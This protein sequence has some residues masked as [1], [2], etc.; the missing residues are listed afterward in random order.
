[1]DLIYSE[2]ID[3]LIIDRG[4]LNNYRFDMSFGADDNDFVLHCPLSGTHLQVNNVVY[5]NDT[6]YGGVIDSI[7]VD[8]ANQEL[9][10]RGR[11]WQGILESKVIYPRRGEDYYT[12][13]GEANAVLADLLERMNI[14]PGA[15]N[16]LI[17]EP[18]GAIISASTEDSGIYITAAAKSTSGN[19]VNGYT[20][21]RDLLYQYSAKPQI[22][23]GVISAVPLINYSNSDDF[24]EGTDQFTAKRNYNSLNHIHCM[25]A[26]D[27][28]NRYEIDLFLD[29][30]GGVLP[31][32]K[33][34][35]YYGLEGAT[36][37]NQ[38]LSDDDYYTDLANFPLVDEWDVK[39]HETLINNMVTGVNEI[40]MI[41]DYPNASTTYHYS[42]QTE[43]PADWTEDLTPSAEKLS[44]KKFGFQQ[45]FY[46][47]ETDGT[48]NYKSVPKPDTAERY[49][50]LLS[51]PEKWA[52]EFNN[53]YVA[54]GKGFKKVTS[55]NEYD[56]VATRPND[57]FMGGYENY[58]EIGTG[59]NY[60]KVTQKSRYERQQEQ[61]PGWFANYTD[62]YTLEGGT[63]KKVKAVKDA[64]TYE[65]L[66][67]KPKDWKNNFK[68]Y[69]KSD[70]ISF[71]A[72]TGITKYKFVKQTYQP[73]DW[74]NNYKN[75]YK[76]ANDK[77]VQLTN[78]TVPKWTTGKYYTKMSY[79]VAPD[80]KTMLYYVKIP[81][82]SHAPFF[83][84]G[85]YYAFVKSIPDFVANH[86]YEK[87]NY[88]R[89]AANTYYKAV[90]YQPAP[91]WYEN[92]FFTRY[93][94]HYEA[95]ING[96]L[97][98]AQKSNPKDELSI[99]LD[100][101]RIY[102][103]NDI[104]GASDEVTG[105]GATERITQKIVKIERGVISFDYKTGI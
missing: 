76:A 9:I 44:D 4:V 10:Y 1:M 7:E 34:M 90:T 79:T 94:D 61:P 45:Y 46:F 72:V 51:E 105:I 86:F 32:C 12:V 3:G 49:D 18:S 100:E 83:Y 98:K 65:K 30:N 73:S 96:A 99:K 78:K 2:V 20:F 89:Y 84:S 93:E 27:W 13:S 25:G 52:S 47:E 104:V 71:S 39:N 33:Y 29:E 54:D 43:Q 62:Y 103:I 56:P 82:A 88:P 55:V 101:S 31:F 17:V 58:Y 66:K 64:D 87:R 77:Y 53:Y 42:L 23:N 35:D 74:K 81:G 91:Q 19:Y 16:T 21:I 26:G 11:T 14:T 95:L 37:N 59:G 70:G 41:Y 63:Y 15:N 5:I 69:Y 36:G 24:L 38:L 40:A 28:G 80:F 57:W 75:Y 6:E 85:T 68:N 67:K 22:I 60:V 50:L 102:D 8:T 97:A 48:A 92:Q